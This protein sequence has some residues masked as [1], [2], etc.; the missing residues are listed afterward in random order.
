MYLE[1][2]NDPICTWKSTTTLQLLFVDFSFCFFVV[3][4]FVCFWG[5]GFTHFKPKRRIVHGKE[6]G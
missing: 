6:I 1:I 4:V 5:E 3:V 2:D